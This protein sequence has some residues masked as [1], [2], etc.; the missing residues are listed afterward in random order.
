MSEIK[1]TIVVQFGGG[2]SAPQGRIIAEVDARPDGLNAGKTSFLPG[3]PVYILV[4]TTPGVSIKSVTPSAGAVYAGPNQNVQDS[5]QF[6]NA[7]EGNLSRPVSGGKVAKWMGN[8][9]GGLTLGADGM[10]VTASR[11][12]VAIARVS[13][14]A[15]AKSYRLSTPV[16][17]NGDTSFEVLIVIEGAES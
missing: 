16:S 13:Y 8:S 14:T 17:L 10:A 4:F 6:A 1:T 7:R 5:V 15:A 9:L 3:D 12:G 2:G 11:S